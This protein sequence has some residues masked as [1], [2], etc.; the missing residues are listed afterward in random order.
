MGGYGS[1]NRYRFGKK[2]TVE[3]CRELDVRDW[4][5]KGY[6]EDTPVSLTI[7]WSRGTEQIAAIGATVSRRGARLSYSFWMGSDE[8]N[9]KSR[10]YDLVARGELPAVRIGERSI[11]INRAELERFLLETRRVVAS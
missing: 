6:L 3:E 2:D 9:K 10:A 1:G 7:N 8:S 11:R 4:S 5:R